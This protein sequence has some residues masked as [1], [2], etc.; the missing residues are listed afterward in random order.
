MS[1]SRPLLGLT[2]GD[3]NGVGPEVLAKA[4]AQEEVWRV[5]RPVVFGSGDALRAMQPFAP[6]CPEVREIT[7]LNAAHFD[8]EWLE[9]LEPGPDV[10]KNTELLPVDMVSW[11]DTQRFIEKLNKDSSEMLFRLPTEAEW[12]YAAR[13]GT[14]DAMYYTGD[15]ITPDRANFNGS[16]PFLA[17]ELTIT[18]L[19]DDMQ[20]RRQLV[21]HGK[22]CVM[23]K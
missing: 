9:L 18:G 23:D 15:T 12:E 17:T 22:C 10:P 14:M 13:G 11:E 21:R 3:V 5:C 6:T 7:T 19:I 20:E 2:M 1:D 16:I 8:E 4:L